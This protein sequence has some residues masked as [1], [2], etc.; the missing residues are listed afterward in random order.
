MKE[1]ARRYRLS[2]D[3]ALSPNDVIVGLSWNVDRDR[4]VTDVVTTPAH[5]ADHIWPVASFC[6]DHQIQLVHGEYRLTCDADGVVEMRKLPLTVSDGERRTLTTAF[7]VALREDARHVSS[8]LGRFPTD[9]QILEAAQ[10][11]TADALHAL[12]RRNK[13]GGDIVLPQIVPGFIQVIA[14]RPKDAIAEISSI[15]PEDL[16]GVLPDELKGLIAHGI[17]IDV[18]LH[19]SRRFGDHGCYAI[20]DDQNGRPQVCV[21][22]IDSEDSG[23]SGALNNMLAERF[24]KAVGLVERD[25]VSDSVTSTDAF[26]SMLLDLNDKVAES[27]GIERVTVKAR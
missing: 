19:N 26:A 16:E 5:D 18:K 14:C 24:R 4:E 21:G 22:F 6:E 8:L 7:A 9:P 17:G 27:Y 25:V 2:P 15:R 12:L 13:P 11:A 3:P 1:Q 20:K 10:V 23:F